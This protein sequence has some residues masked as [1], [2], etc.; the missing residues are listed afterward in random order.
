MFIIE[1]SELGNKN[2]V[3]SE[4]MQIENIN[5][6]SLEKALENDAKKKGINIEDKL[7]KTLNLFK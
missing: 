3:N 2:F 7:F 5:K 4:N 1:L 6:L